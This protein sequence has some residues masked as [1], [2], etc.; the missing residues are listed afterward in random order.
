MSYTQWIKKKKSLHASFEMAGFSDAKSALGN[1]SKMCYNKGLLDG[2]LSYF[3]PK[4]S[5]FIII[6]SR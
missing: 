2:C 6:I 4:R 3:P 5:I 1:T